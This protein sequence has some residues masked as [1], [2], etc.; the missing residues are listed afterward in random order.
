MNINIHILGSKISSI[1]SKL[2][3]RLNRTSRPDVRNLGRTF[4]ISA[5]RSKSRPGVQN[6]GC[7]EKNGNWS[8]GPANGLPEI[9]LEASLILWIWIFIFGSKRYQIL[10]KHCQKVANN[11]FHFFP[12]MFQNSKIF[13]IYIFLYFL[14]CFPYYFL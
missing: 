4:E 2:Q 14:N 11:V 6:R 12:K 7:A 9:F 8:S 3:K 13:H 10:S 1:V 5:R